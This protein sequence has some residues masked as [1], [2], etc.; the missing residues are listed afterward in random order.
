[1]DIPD[2]GIVLIVDDNPNNLSVLS[3]ALKA[4]GL[5][6]RVAVDG[7]SA[8]EQVEYDPP[9]LILLD[10][11]MP[12]IDGFET[13]TRLKDNPSTRDIPVIF[14]TVLEN[15]ESKLKGLSL[16]AVD[17]ITKPFQE[18]EAIARVKLHLK[19]RHLAKTLETQNV[20]LKQEVSERT[21]AETALQRLTQ[22]LELRVEQRTAELRQAKESA[23]AANQAKSE[24]L[25]KM[26]HELRTPLNAILG[27]TQ[28]MGSDPS[29]KP[30]H[31]ENLG[32]ISRSGEHLL[33]LI[34]DVLEM[35]KIEV[36][37]TKL[38]NNRLD[39]HHLLDSLEEMLQLKSKSKGLTLLFIRPPD[40][41]QF[42]NADESKLR[43]VLINLL[44]NAI[45]FTESGTVTLR[46]KYKKGEI[47][48]QQN[49]TLSFRNS[50]LYTL[51]FE[52]EDTGPGIA[53]NEIEILFN[54]FV[55]TKAGQNS[56]EGTGL[57]LSISQQ[58]VQ[59]MGGEIAVNSK[60]GQGTIFE[61]K[62]PVDLVQVAET[63]TSEKVR[64]VVGIAPNQPE[65]RV[66]VVE[67]DRVSRLVLVRLLK[68]I[69]FH[70]REATNGQEAVNLWEMWHPH[71]IWM[72]MQMPIMN[73]YEATQQI[74]NKQQKVPLIGD[75][76]RWR[77]EERE[78]PEKAQKTIFQSPV[79]NQKS[80]IKS[81][82]VIIALTASA[83][84]EDRAAILAGGCDDFVSKPFRKQFVLDKM[85]QYLGVRYLYE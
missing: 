16:G 12:G 73:G 77:D 64:K 56:Q 76:G 62:I 5:T 40:L 42:V 8:I 21:S 84:E 24:F 11:M 74:K 69:G 26:S 37:R 52:I 18:E 46:V 35:S 4:A 17:Y 13:C 79:Q 25:A 65:Y 44:G 32:I 78:E 70:V 75:R 45:K 61:F 31:Q 58:F 55:Q 50:A 82:T 33:A 41:P 68:S 1:M 20:R 72:D 54:P 83:F 19:L 57:G 23:D 47:R 66:L 15:V 2:T 6:V 81:P 85:A 7:E 10:V 9:Q 36:G 53:Q 29:L 38:N 3:K 14:M 43:Q 39:L 59:L 48:Q 51:L 80:K 71:L 34:N 60:L 28:L 30:E 67:D 27:F 22:E 49:S 63:E